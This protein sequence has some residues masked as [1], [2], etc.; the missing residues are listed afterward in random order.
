[1]NRR[2][3][4]YKHTKLTRSFK[5]F[6]SNFEESLAPE[7]FEKLLDSLD[8]GIVQAYDKIMTASTGVARA[9]RLH[10]L[11]EEEIR[12]D[13][14]VKPTCL[15][16]CSACCHLEVEITSHEAQLLASLLDNG[17]A[18]DE[19]RLKA[20]SER[21]PQDPKWKEGLRNEENRCVF[22]GSDKA[23]GIYEHRP[24][25]CRRHAVSSPPANCE[26]VDEKITVLY[27]P[28]VDILLV[29][30]SEDS[31]LRTGPLAKMLRLKR[32][33]SLRL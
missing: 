13:S 16:G 6:V 32:E 10:E 26:T 18:V 3:F 11:V 21:L 9:R 29:A 25:M 30:A 22:L 31:D 28:R 4:N 1:M 14:S 23:C 2:E 24:A 19:A 15:K 5:D 27:L 33:N 8:E 12:N 20:Q 7:D 17:Y